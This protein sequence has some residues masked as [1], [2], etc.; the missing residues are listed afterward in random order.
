M[1]ARLP[2]LAYNTIEISQNAGSYH[3]QEQTRVKFSDIILNRLHVNRK[4][5]RLAIYSNRALD[6]SGK[7]NLVFHYERRFVPLA[8][9]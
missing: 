7:G 2:H 6:H 4:A 5:S 3:I 8:L 1:Y 9:A